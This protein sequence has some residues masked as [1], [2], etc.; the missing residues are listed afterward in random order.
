MVQNLFELVDS[1]REEMINT[2]INLVRMRALSPENGGIGE[3]DKAEYLMDFLKE[4]DVKRFDAEDS[5]AKDG[6]R[7]NIVAKLKG[8]EK[9]N[10]WIVSHLDVVP[11]GDISLWKT[12]P[13]EPTILDGKI[14]G[15][16]SEDNG[17][18]IVSS[19]F[20]AKAI[21]KLGLTPKY[22]LCLSFVSDEESGCKYGIEHLIKQ[23]IFR[24][25]DLFIVPDAGASKG[26]RIQIAEKG[27]LWLKFLVRGIQ[28]HASRPDK[29]DNAF[30]KAMKFLL[31][32]DEKLHTNFNK[33]ND[34]FIPPT[35]TFEP[36][37]REKNV[38]NVN[39]IPGLDIS[40]MDC[41]ILPEYSIEDVLGVIDDIRKSYDSIDREVLMKLTSPPTSEKSDVVELLQKAIRTV[42]GVESS[43]F[44]TGVYTC[45]AF[46]RR[47]GFDVAVWCTI[48]GV[49]HQPNE[50]AVIENMVSDAKVFAL[51][52]FIE[53]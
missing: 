32:I 51:L 48:D 19:L 53:I 2:L 17:Q 8:Q 49:G 20:A 9:R 44:G 25:D 35:S 18:S 23:N 12:P 29:G 36:T 39:T 5:R 4:F 24:K 11:E 14:Y 22:T 26:N 41:R 31:E 50:Y 42:R 30:R 21:K 33:T 27:V 10:I 15:R 43:F 37:K 46:L 38:D 28:S 34:L 40:Y 7:P 52:P 13:F 6:I 47:A 45:A 16:G 1:S 3:V